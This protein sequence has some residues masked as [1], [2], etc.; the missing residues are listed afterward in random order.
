MDWKN[1]TLRLLQTQPSVHYWTALYIYLKSVGGLYVLLNVVLLGVI[2]PLL[3]YFFTNISVI[4]GSIG[5]F[6]LIIQFISYFLTFI[7]NQGIPNMK[8]TLSEQLTRNFSKRTLNIV[9][10]QKFC[11][12]CGL[13]KRNCTNITHC[14]DCQICVEGFDHHCPWTG[15]CVGSKNML[16][17]RTFLISTIV[18]IL[19]IIL[20]TC[21]YLYS[22]YSDL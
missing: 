21:I 3:Y 13:M 14:E 7:I 22:S 5:A 9:H 10:S 8:L 18:L 20:I 11:E 6:I 4:A 17:F 16:F 2:I 1:S 12:I 19:Y 15:K